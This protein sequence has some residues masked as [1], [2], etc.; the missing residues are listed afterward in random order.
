MP[1]YDGIQNNNYNEMLCQKGEVKGS[2]DFHWFH[3]TLLK[4]KNWKPY[5][6]IPVNK[7]TKPAQNRKFNPYLS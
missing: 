1:K 5:S 6:N 2:L 4:E 7:G 3:L